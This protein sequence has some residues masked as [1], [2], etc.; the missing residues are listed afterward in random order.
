MCLT[1]VGAVTEHAPSTA[2]KRS[3]LKKYLISL[4]LDRGEPAIGD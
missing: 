4:D 2:I 1:I 3:S